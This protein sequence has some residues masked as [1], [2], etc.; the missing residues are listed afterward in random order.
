MNRREH[1][2][3]FPSQLRVKLGVVWPLLSG[4]ISVMVVLGCAL[5]SLEGWSL[6]ESIYFS[7]VQGAP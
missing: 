1:R 5:G 6:Q 7:F 3:R 2:R 4:L